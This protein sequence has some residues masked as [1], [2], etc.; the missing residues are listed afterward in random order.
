MLSEDTKILE[1]NQYQ[2]SDRARFIF[3]ADAECLIEK[4]LGCKNNPENSSTIKVSEHIPP[5]FSNVTNIVI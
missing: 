5:G 4:T 2:K 1:P 3:Y